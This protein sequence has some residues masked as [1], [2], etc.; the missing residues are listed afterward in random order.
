MVRL[1]TFVSVPGIFAAPELCEVKSRVAKQVLHCRSEFLQHL[2][3][4]I[5]PNA[6]RSNPKNLPDGFRPDGFRLEALGFDIPF[7]LR[8][9]SFAAFRHLKTSPRTS[10]T[11]TV[12]W[13]MPWLWF[14]SRHTKFNN[15]QL[16][17]TQNAKMSHVPWP[18]P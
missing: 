4:T 2:S 8:R 16:T 12:I 17:H 14:R 18:S 15:R 13:S 5:R 11:C 10:K 9:I 6:R 1:Q 7:V 3:K